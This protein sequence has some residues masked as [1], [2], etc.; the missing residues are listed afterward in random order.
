MKTLSIRTPWNGRRSTLA[1]VLLAAL[2]ATF[3]AADS[4]ADQASPFFETQPLYEGQ[5][6][7][8]VV[9]AVDGTILAFRAGGAPVEVRRS[10]DGGA[11]W[12]PAI[13]VGGGKTNL[14][15]AIVDDTTGN[16]MVFQGRQMF[17]SSDAGK[18]WQPRETTI[19]PDDLGGIGGTHGADSGITLQFG[20]HKGRLLQPARVVVPGLD[21]DPKRWPYHYNSAIYSDDGGTT[22][23]TSHPFPVLGTGEGTL[24][25]L[26]DG[27]VYYNSRCHMAT[28]AMRRTA[29]SFDGGATWINPE[30]STVLPDGPRGARYGCAGGLTRLPA[31]E[32]DV[33]VYS[34][35][36]FEGGS[37]RGEGRQKIT[38]WASLDGAKTWPVKRLVYDGPAAYSSLAAGRPGTPSEGLVY[39][40]YEG[41]PDGMYSAIHLARFN[42]AWL[43]EGE[44]TGDGEL[45]KQ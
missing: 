17:G 33:L 13:E 29:W 28:D 23:Q 8:S 31:E 19:Q 20:E 21:N 6:F 7:P 16:I 12:G 43:L 3:C 34:N 22:W 15:A 38:V 41:G 9:V 2:P 5:R 40:L 24:A 14:G 4:R 27:R 25:E 45:P 39:L 42:L 37:G 11:T 32:K 36:D 26:S 10:E 44:P 18:T 1:A 35:L 30:T